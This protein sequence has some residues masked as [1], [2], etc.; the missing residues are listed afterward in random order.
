[1]SE[2]QTLKYKIDLSK[3]PKKTTAPTPMSS[4]S[5]GAFEI[6]TAPSTQVLQIMLNDKV[7]IEINDK[8]V[9]IHGISIKGISQVLENHYSALKQLLEK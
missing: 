1:M 9:F 2:N 5:F 3:V 8:D 4:I 6:K 7:L